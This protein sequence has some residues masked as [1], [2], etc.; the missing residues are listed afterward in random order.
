[1]PFLG[2]AAEKRKQEKA[3]EKAQG[4]AKC[5]PKAKGKAKAKAN[6]EVYPTELD[7]DVPLEDEWPEDDDDDDDDAVHANDEWDGEEWDEE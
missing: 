1:M 6:K 5:K 2:I 4:K 7:D 3:L